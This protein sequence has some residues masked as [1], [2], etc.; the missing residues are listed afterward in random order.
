MPRIPRTINGFAIDFNSSVNPEMDQGI[1]N[2]LKHCIKRE[3]APGCCGALV[4]AMPVN[5]PRLRRNFAIREM[6]ENLAL[7]FP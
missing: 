3:I 7:C 4:V 1:I 6:R 2:G 5:L